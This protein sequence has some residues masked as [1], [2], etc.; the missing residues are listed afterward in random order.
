[1]DRTKTIFFRLGGADY[2]VI[3]ACSSRTATKYGVFAIALCV[4][5]ALAFVGGADIAHQYIPVETPLSTH[6]AIC[7]GVGL[8]W[9]ALIFTYDFGI[10]NIGNLGRLGSALRV[11]S[12]IAA[13]F[14][15]I[16]A[17]NILMAQKKVDNRINADKA[18]ALKGVDEAYLSERAARF[19]LVNEKKERAEKYNNEVVMAEANR[20]Y[21]GPRYQE[22][23]AAYDA[24]ITNV[25]AELKQLNDQ[26]VPYLTAYQSERKEI[27]SR[28]SGDYM[29]KAETLFKVIYDGGVVSIMTALALYV[30]FAAFEMGVLA[31]KATTSPDDEYHQKEDQYNQR[32]EA[33]RLEA[34]NADA[35]LKREQKRLDDQKR[36]SD[37][38]ADK[39]IAD[40]RDSDDKI[41]QERR[42]RG[43]IQVLRS[44]GYLANADALEA[45]LQHLTTGRGAV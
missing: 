34:A 16:T 1:M 36:R 9:S 20:V 14:L 7:V 29:M 23:K 10:L 2:N 25:N 42:L 37:L 43:R 38:R 5:V 22:K 35:E 32:M 15:T 28:G 17:L 12:G 19:K 18:A 26:E 41:I 24:L 33:V 13:V 6:I 3:R 31:I 8:A 11:V 39:D 45:D 27:V 30:V 44:K 21:P 40:M 4:S